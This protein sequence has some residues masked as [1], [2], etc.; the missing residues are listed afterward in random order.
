MPTRLIH[1]TTE[2]QPS[3]LQDYQDGTLIIG[4]FD[5]VHRGHSAL[6]KHMAENEDLFPRPHLVFSFQPHPMAFFKPEQPQFQLTSPEQKLAILS[7]LD[8]DGLIL[9]TFNQECASLTPEEFIKTITCDMFRTKAIITG[10]DFH[11]GK[12]RAGNCE[13]LQK[14]SMEYGFYYHRMQEQSDPKGQRFT[15][16]MV[17]DAIKQGD[18]ARACDLMGRPYQITGEVIKGEQL[19]RQLNM[20]TAN[21]LPES[22]CRPAYGIYV[23]T[24]QFADKYYQAIANFGTRPAV[25]GTYPLL[26]VHLFDFDDDLYGQNLSINFW[27]LLRAECD[28]PSLEA[29]KTQMHQDCADAKQYF[30]SRKGSLS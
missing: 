9:M 7:G 15:S 6:I 28:F 10:D 24:A 17:R 18:M 16:T 5:G 4:N 27:H 8:I 21:I 1:I 29:L 25:G 11:F 13:T 30:Q 14:A 19:G 3:E 2:T 22:Y 12:G 26:E 23:V 20:P